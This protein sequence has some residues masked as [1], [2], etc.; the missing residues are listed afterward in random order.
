[1]WKVTARPVAFQLGQNCVYFFSVFPRQHTVSGHNGPASETPWRWRFTG[2]PMM[3]SFLCLMSYLL[4]NANVK[5]TWV[6]IVSIQTGA[7]I[8]I[9]TSQTQFFFIK[10]IKARLRMLDIFSNLI[11]LKI[12]HEFAYSTCISEFYIVP[13]AGVLNVT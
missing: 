13:I 4:P 5:H 3:A 7:S 2:G 9:D 10:C 1:M 11:Y 6:C 8:K 12:S